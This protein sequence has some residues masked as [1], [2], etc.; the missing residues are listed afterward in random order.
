[1]F[2]FSQF[3]ALPPDLQ[4]EE[5]GCLGVSLDLACT[6]ANAEALLFAYADFYVE[7][8]V[9]KHTDEILALRCFKSIRKLAPYLHQIDLSDIHPLL[10]C[11]PRT[12]RQ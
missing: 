5:L 12:G 4:Y 6:T 3:R 10:S 2:T 7:L 1:M 9:A 8:V 11:T